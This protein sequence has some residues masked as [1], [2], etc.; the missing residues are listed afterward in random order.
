MYSFRAALRGTC[1][2]R[3]RATGRSG[4]WYR[5][6]AMKRVLVNE[7]LLNAHSK[8]LNVNEPRWAPWR[9]AASS[10]LRTRRS[11][12]ILS[13]VSITRQQEGNS[14]WSPY[15]TNHRYH[16]QRHYYENWGTKQCCDRSEQKFL[17]IVYTPICVIL[18][19]LV[20]NEVK[21]I[22]KWICLGGKTAVWWG[23]FPPCPFLATSLT[24]WPL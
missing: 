22:F 5:Q 3:G 11:S 9:S 20:A 23:Q 2:T 1:Q 10:I 15:S 17:Y 6:A 4:R 13:P 16:W 7:H 24:L 14:Y 8:T 12:G 18:G 19:T 21:K